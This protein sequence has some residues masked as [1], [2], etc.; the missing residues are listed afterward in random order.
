[1]FTTAIIPALGA[2]IEQQQKAIEVAERTTPRPEPVPYEHRPSVRSA[3]PSDEGQYVTWADIRAANE[4]KREILER[5]R[6][7]AEAQEQ[8]EER[9]PEQV[10]AEATEGEMGGYVEEA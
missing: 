9:Q 3:P 8:A 1:M 10:Q 4:R 5:Q 6:A 7:E 2:L